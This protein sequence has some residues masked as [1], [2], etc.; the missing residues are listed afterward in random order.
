M[1]WAENAA[2]GQMV[3]RVTQGGYVSNLVKIGP[4]EVLGIRTD[5]RTAM[6]G[7]YARGMQNFIKNIYWKFFCVKFLFFHKNWGE[8]ENFTNPAFY[9]FYAS[10]HQ[11]LAPH[12]VL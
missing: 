7:L 9:S 8:V 6:V 11:N 5:K 12:S 10:P 3:V 2:T 1:T 4:R